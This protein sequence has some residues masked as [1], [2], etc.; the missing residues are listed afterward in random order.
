MPR[1]ANRA[2][3]AAPFFQ[4]DLNQGLMGGDD[5]RPEGDGPAVLLL[6]L[7]AWLCAAA[8]ASGL[9]WVVAIAARG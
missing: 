6:R 9:G 8:L 4:R 2:A 7:A 1:D 3:S 5:Y